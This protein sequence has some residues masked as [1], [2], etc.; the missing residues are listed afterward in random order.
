MEI[1]KDKK[2][3]SS[4]MSNSERLGIQNSDIQKLMPPVST[5]SNDS[6]ISDTQ[7]PEIPVSE[8]LDYQN[9]LPLPIQPAISRSPTTFALYCLT[10]PQ[11]PTRPSHWSCDP[12]W[13]YDTARSP[14]NIDGEESN[15]SDSDNSEEG[16]ILESSSSRKAKGKR[17]KKAPRNRKN[18]EAFKKEKTAK[19]LNKTQKVEVEEGANFHALRRRSQGHQPPPVFQIHPLEVRRLYSTFTLQQVQNGLII[20]DSRQRTLVHLFPLATI[21]ANLLE[22]L[23]SSFEEY[24]SSLTFSNYDYTVRHTKNADP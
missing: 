5:D 6:G 10:L 16:T 15:N 20:R 22:T 17:K 14:I 19:M 9:S 1:L 3:A 11:P 23:S 13:H 7:E 12:A 2:L 21:P 18:Q 8:G 4:T 24:N